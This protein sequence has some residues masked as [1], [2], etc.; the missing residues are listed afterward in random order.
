[1]NRQIPAN[2]GKRGKEEKKG[3][4][5]SIGDRSLKEYRPGAD[6]A[7]VYELLV[8]RGRGKKE[9]K[10]EGGELFE[11]WLT[12]QMKGSRRPGEPASALGG[13]LS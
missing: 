13:T 2:L 4:E 10:K 11:L 8:Q 12:V 7:F 6:S 5:Q 3:D 9:N 1:M